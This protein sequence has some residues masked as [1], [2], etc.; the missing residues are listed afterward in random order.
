MVLV[1]LPRAV[2]VGEGVLK[3]G[4]RRCVCGGVHFKSKGLGI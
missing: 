4:A 1:V 3:R 2:C